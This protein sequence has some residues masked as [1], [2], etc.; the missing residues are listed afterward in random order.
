M[1]GEHGG[2]TVCVTGASGFIGSWLVMRL[3]ERGY[4][5]R[6]TVRD[7]A[8]MSKV[9]HLLDLPNAGTYLSL[10]KADLTEEGS[11]DDAIHGCAGVFHVATPMEF[12][13]VMDPESEVIK[14][15][16]NGALNI[17]RS[18]SKAKTV[19][20]VIYTSTTGTI[21]IQ[22]HPQSEYDES[23]WTDVDFCKAQKMTG[24]MYFVAKTMAE[25]AAWEFAKENDLDL[26][27]IQPS[28][29]LG[30]FI[31]P[32]RPTSIEISIA[33]ITRNEAFYP[34]LTQARA[35]HLDDLCNAHIYL[36]EYPQASGR[37]ICSSHCFTIFDIAKWLSQKYPEC[38]IPTKFEGVDESL[39][40]IPCSSKKL[41][42]L[43][44]KFKYN[45]DECHVG[46]LFTEAIESCRQKGLMPL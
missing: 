31:T 29:V 2:T 28:I 4:Y 22:Q 32:S 25:K 9:K 1:E 24:W 19:K 40:P 46:V 30:P 36:L 10:W 5:I 34:M 18:C 42:D 23:F 16:V 26:V 21:V 14:P 44:F 3:L 41:V 38:D 8:N 33:L 20:R 35:V 11:F 37:Y 43:G 45:S 15:T 12:I 7:P 27:T 13:S 17:M 39:K 6:A